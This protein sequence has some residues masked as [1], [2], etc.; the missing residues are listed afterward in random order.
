MTT[1]PDSFFRYLNP[2]E[3]E[4]F[5]QWA[6]DNWEDKEPDGC[7]HPIVRDEWVKITQEKSNG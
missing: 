5:R 1:L 3:E 7:W 2:D 6:R 4:Q